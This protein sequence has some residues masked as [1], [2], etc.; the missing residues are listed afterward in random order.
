VDRQSF[1]LYKKEQ[2][3][4]NLVKYL[5]VLFDGGVTWKIHM[6]TLAAKALGIFI[7]LLAIQKWAIKR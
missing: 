4:V 7:S 6:Q 2:S 3:F 5:S 1:T